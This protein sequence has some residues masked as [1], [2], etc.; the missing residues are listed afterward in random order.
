MVHHKSTTQRERYIES[1]DESITTV[2]RRH[3]VEHMNPQPP[4]SLLLFLLIL[5]LLA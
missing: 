3:F 1:Q 4:P 2:F 5:F